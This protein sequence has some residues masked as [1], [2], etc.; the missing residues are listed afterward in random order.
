MKKLLNDGF[1]KAIGFYFSISAIILSVISIIIYSTFDGNLTEYYNSNVIIPIIF[2]ILL[3]AGLSVFKKT[4]N[5]APIV[6]WVM[7]FITFLLYVNYIYM[8]FSGVF[9]NGVTSDALKL[10]DSRVISSLI[11]IILSC[12]LGNVAIYL[13]NSNE[14]NVEEKI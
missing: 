8:Y 5:Y 2:G 7:T 9:Y 14:W 1:Y 12:I 10:V 11:L 4:A 3:F 6:L 13:K